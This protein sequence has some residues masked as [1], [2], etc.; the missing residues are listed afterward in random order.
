MHDV[1]V[2]GVGCAGYTT[3]I[4]CARYKLSVVIIGAEE[5]GMGMSA[6]EVGNWPGDIEIAG[7]EL[8]ERFKKHALSFESVT[9]MLKW[10]KSVEKNGDHFVLTLDGG[11]T[12]EAKTV[13]FATGSNKRKLGIP[14]EKEFSGKGVTY[15][16]TCDAFF[17]RN[18]DVAVLGG[19]DS[20]VEG[21]AIV[22]QV[23][24]K[25]YLV[26]R[27]DSFRAEPYWVDKVKEKTN[28]EFVLNTNALEVVG[29]QKVTHLK[30][31]VPYNGEEML[32]VDG[33]FIEIGSVPATELC[34]NMGCE[35]DD[36]GFLKVDEG[37]RASVEGVFGA[38][39]VTSGSN[40]FAQFATAAG[41]G[42]VAANSV[43]SYLEAGH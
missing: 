19:G 32:K 10:V 34:K 21:A 43:F 2:I 23:A 15:C 3:A 13:V 40:H 6:A 25:V 18:K 41:E 28:I 29:D 1:A 24:R 17:Y 33:V 42:A 26:H 8:M 37:M 7:P 14:G 16:A 31:D 27:R 5:G 20:A 36:R 9:H 22:A 12:V 38:G 30:I 35:L 11:Q 4:Y 39:D